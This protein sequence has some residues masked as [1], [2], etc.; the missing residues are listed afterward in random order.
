M[1]NTPAAQ[2]VVLIEGAAPLV[3]VL[4]GG[5]SLGAQDGAD[6]GTGGAAVAQ[7]EAAAF[8]QLPPELAQAQLGGGGVNPFSEGQVAFGGAPTG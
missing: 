5:A 3:S 1:A 2:I 4:L 7:A 6:L 8:Q